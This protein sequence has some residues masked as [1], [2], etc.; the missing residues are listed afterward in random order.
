VKRGGSQVF[1]TASA[2]HLPR[3]EPRELE[4]SGAPKGGLVQSKRR[5]ALLRSAAQLLCARQNALDFE[6]SKRTVHLSTRS[7]AFCNLI[8]TSHNVVCDAHGVAGELNQFPDGKL[9]EAVMA[10]KVKSDLHRQRIGV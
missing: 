9:N 6:W 10:A 7:V 4:N 1:T 8:A 3:R 5:A 2:F